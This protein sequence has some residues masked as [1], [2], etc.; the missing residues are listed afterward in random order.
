M[1]TLKSWREARDLSLSQAAEEASVTP[2]MWSR[3]ENLRR[4]IPAERVM[5]LARLTSIPAHDLRP[6]I[7]PEPVEAGE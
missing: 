7:Y 6:D 1:A 4:R 3:W 5:D 2:A